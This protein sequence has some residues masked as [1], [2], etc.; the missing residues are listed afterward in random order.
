MT[1]RL[2]SV[3]V[4]AFAASALIAPA[5]ASASTTEAI[6][7][8]GGMTLTLGVLGSPLTTVSVG[9]DDVG[10]ITEVALSDPALT[11]TTAGDHKVRF[12]N[13]DGTTRV[14]VKAKKDKLSAE[15][16]A[17]DL[18][19]ILGTHTWTGV[20]FG[21]DDASTVMF[22]VVENADGNPEV[23]N[24]SVTALFPADAT[25]E[26]GTVKN[27]TDDDEAES[28]MKITFMSNGF[29]MTLKIKAEMELGHDDDDNGDTTVK[30]KIE[31]KGKDQQK[32]KDQALADLVGSYLWDGRYCDGTPLTI[33]YSISDTGDVIVDGVT[34]DGAASD[35]YEL[36]T[37]NYGFEVKFNDSDAKVKVELKQNDGLW[38]LKVKSETTSKCDESDSADNSDDDDGDGDDGD[39]GDHNGNSDDDGDD[40]D[41][42][43]NSGGDDDGDDGDDGD[44]NGNSGG[45]DDGDD[46]DHNGNSG[47]DDDGDD[48]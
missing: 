25:Y 34:I 39:D 46:G 17:A 37:K 10:H 6:A 19:A 28:S 27:K 11:E 8:T 31:L 36:K 30:L 23:T 45:D 20:L 4:I 38:D 7:D 12:S 33:S 47:G 32:L 29:T 22:D 21:A 18:A 5:A 16:K 41:H 1:K 26:I 43:G 3:L 40:G 48:D 13:E 14:E 9:L 15:V 35:A 24:V 42:N 2:A 44:H